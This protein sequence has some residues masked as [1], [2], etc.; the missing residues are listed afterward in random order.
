[1]P[2]RYN[3]Q[4]VVFAMDEL[5]E[6]KQGLQEQIITHD[7]RVLAD[8]SINDVHRAALRAR[9]AIARSALAKTD[10][11]LEQLRRKNRQ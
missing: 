11:A 5:A 10:L 1:M 9:S 8:H 2:V 6:I 4:S 3:T 7:A